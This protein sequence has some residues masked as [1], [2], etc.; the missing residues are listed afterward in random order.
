MRRMN[1]LRLINL[2]MVKVLSRTFEERDQLLKLDAVPWRVVLNSTQQCVATAVQHSA[3]VS[4]LVIM[5]Q[6]R[7]IVGALK[8]ADGAVP[9][10]LLEKQ[11]SCFL[12]LGGFELA[13]HPVF[14]GSRWCHHGLE[15]GF[16][17]N[18]E[19]KIVTFNRAQQEVTILDR[20]DI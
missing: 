16:V 6:Y 3:N 17:F 1:E 18:R 12:D 4:A 10:L 15:A 2:M 13:N 19:H 5:V 7:L 8:A 14:T 11:G 20:D 9:T